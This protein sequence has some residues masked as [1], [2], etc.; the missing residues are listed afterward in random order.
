MGEVGHLISLLGFVAVVEGDR[1][2]SEGDKKSKMRVDI[3]SPYSDYGKAER[4]A[5]VVVQRFCGCSSVVELLVANETVERSNRFTR[6]FSPSPL[7]GP[8]L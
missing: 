6:F 4:Q 8:A 3:G 2:L 7:L 5:S 1:Y